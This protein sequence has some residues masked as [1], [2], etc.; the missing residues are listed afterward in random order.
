M[1]D[2]Q[3]TTSAALA[4]LA[5]NTQGN[6]S[7]QDLRDG[8]VTYQM[9]HGQIYVAAADS[10]AVT[11]SDTTNYFEMNSGPTWTLTSGAH[12]FDMSAGNG[13]LTYTGTADVWMHCALSLSFTTA[14][15]NRLLHVRLGVS[16][17]TDAAS[18]AQRWVSTGSD[19]GST[20]VH[21]VARL[22]NGDYVSAFLR[23]ATNADNATVQVCNLQ[24]VTMPVSS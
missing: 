18:E 19:V 7:P 15:N 6:I 2:T 10:G 5:D 22:T 20:A 16:G 8:F 23:N 11:I 13:R 12:D 4:L 24:V 21:L 9:R 14:Q 1:A 17:T 3:R